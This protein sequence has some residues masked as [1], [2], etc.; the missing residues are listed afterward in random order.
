MI[1]WDDRAI[2]FWILQVIHTTHPG[3]SSEPPIPQGKRAIV[4]DPVQGAGRGKGITRN[5]LVPPKQFP[6]I[7]RDGGGRSPSPHA[8]PG[9]TLPVPF[10]QPQCPA[11]QSGGPL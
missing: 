7:E 3:S 11:P 4:H 5:A 2:F 6:L 1:Q 8:Y 10:T 9:M